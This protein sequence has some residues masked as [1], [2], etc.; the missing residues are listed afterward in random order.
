MAILVSPEARRERDKRM[1]KDA[2]R[3][4]LKLIAAAGEIMRSDGGDVPMELIAERAGVTRGTLYRNF[5]HR[6][7][8]V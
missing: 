5:E 2:E 3:N 4:R 7:G 1:R 6:Q 8:H